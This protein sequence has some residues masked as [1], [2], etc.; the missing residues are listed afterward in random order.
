[1]PK[2]LISDHRIYDAK[3]RLTGQSKAGA[4]TTFVLDSVGN[5]LTKWHQ[6]QQPLTFTYDS[7]QRI[8]TLQDGPTR[9]TYTYDS[10]GNMTKEEREAVITNYTY[11]RENRLSKKDTGGLDVVTILYDI[12]G[13]RRVQQT[14]TSIVTTIWDGSDYVGEDRT[15]A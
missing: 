4:V 2:P 1:M 11:D 7:A 5:L 3:D 9:V 15:G 6:G 14:A 10:N 13:L 8:L 12:N